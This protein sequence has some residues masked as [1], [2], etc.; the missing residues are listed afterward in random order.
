ML[1]GSPIYLAV[2]GDVYDVSDGRA[3]YGPDGGYGGFSGRDAT[4]FFI[5]F[6]DFFLFYNHSN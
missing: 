5:L 3:H 2:A 4:R 1:D 6:F